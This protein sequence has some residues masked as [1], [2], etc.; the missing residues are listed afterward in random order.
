M[1][2]EGTTVEMCHHRSCWTATKA[3]VVG[4]YNS[5]ENC[6]KIRHRTLAEPIEI[7]DVR[8]LMNAQNVTEN[9]EV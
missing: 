9:A 7:V 5:Q 3:R 1:R 4:C 8:M 2:L 6:I